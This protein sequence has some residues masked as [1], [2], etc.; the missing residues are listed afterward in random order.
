LSTGASDF[1]GGSRKQ[2]GRRHD[3]ADEVDERI[4]KL[5]DELADLRAVR[6]ANED[7]RKEAEQPFGLARLRGVTRNEKY[8]DQEETE[9]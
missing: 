7:L 2:P 8:P 1:A 9:E 3:V 6:E 4:K 5:E